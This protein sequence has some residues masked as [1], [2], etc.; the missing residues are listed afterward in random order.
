MGMVGNPMFIPT[1][2]TWPS[3]FGTTIF[4]FRCT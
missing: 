4:Q 3:K 1:P 2:F